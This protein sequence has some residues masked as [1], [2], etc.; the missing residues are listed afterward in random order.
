MTATSSG[1]DPRV[2]D[3]ARTERRH[4]LDVAFRMLGDFAA[5]EDMVQEAFVRL[6]RADLDEIEDV[7]GW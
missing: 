3:I 7:R 1:F 2:A 4:L 5:A 6:A